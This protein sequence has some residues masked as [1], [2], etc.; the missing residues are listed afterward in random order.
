[1]KQF[2]CGDVV[3][4]CTAVFVAQDEPGILAQVGDHARKD[5]GIKSVTNEL[6][7]QVRGKI[8]DIAAK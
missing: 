1:M 5:H 2:C 8:Q 3:P 4:G 7:Q 6:V